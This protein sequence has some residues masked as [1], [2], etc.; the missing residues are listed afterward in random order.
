M[1][2]KPKEEKSGKS[3]AEELRLKHLR[4]QLKNQE[5][6]L[7]HQVPKLND[8]MREQSRA[9][10]EQKIRDLKSLIAKGSK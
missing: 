1:A 6:K 7:E 3:A 10:T 8:D 2:D 5:R 9:L 4:A